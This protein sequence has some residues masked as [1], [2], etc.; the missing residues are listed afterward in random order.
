MNQL[1]GKI[2][3]LI[4]GGQTELKADSTVVDFTTAEPVILREGAEVQKIKEAIQ[5]IK[6]GKFLRKKILIVCTG[7]SCRSP[8]AEGWLGNELRHRLLS[9]QI[10]L[11]SC[12]IG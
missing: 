12:G 10:E 8:M 1:G 5:K 3:Y 9:A 2:D 6:D 11:S 7:N 4:D